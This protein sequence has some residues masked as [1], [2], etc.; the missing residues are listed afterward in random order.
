[1]IPLSKLGVSS[2]KEKQFRK[3]GITCAEEL[4]SFFPRKYQDY[5]E[6]KAVKDLR[7]GDI[8]R[9][10]G[11]ITN[12]YDDTRFVIT[13]DDGTGDIA[14]T[15]FGGCYYKKALTPG[16]LWTFCGKVS[17]FRGQPQIVQPAMSAPGENRLAHI[18]PFY[19]KIQGM[20]D[21]YLT[22]KIDASLSVMAAG[23]V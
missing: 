2:A 21:K 9:V 3:K 15:W 10:S 14:I 7:D 18:H 13:L 23:S 1:M 5:R 16:S 8:C 22:E 6:K 4:A 19:S 12:V 17:Y 11:V 20:S